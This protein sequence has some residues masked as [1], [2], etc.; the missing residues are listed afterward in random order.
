MPHDQSVVRD[1]DA[2]LWRDGEREAFG[3]V[4]VPLFARGSAA[5]AAGC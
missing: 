5:V 1:S 4:S 3:G 2:G